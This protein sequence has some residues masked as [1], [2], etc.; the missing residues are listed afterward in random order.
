MPMKSPAWDGSSRRDHDHPEML[1]IHFLHSER[2][3][4]HDK[5]GCGYCIF[6]CCSPGGVSR[7]GARDVDKNVRFLPVP[8]KIRVIHFPTVLVVDGRNA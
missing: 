4:R 2:Q 5:V 1:G 6:I 3:V 8:K 7:S